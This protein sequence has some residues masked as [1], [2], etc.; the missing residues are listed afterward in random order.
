MDEVHL[1]EDEMTALVPEASLSENHL[2]QVLRADWPS[3][4]E[5]K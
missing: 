5:S 3:T 4:E 2:R 1:G